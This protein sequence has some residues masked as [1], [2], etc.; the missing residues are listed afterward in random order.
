MVHILVTSISDDQFQLVTGGDDNSLCC[1][2]LTFNTGQPKVMTSACVKS[3][4][5]AQITGTGLIIDL[6]VA[7]SKIL[8]SKF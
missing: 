3:A 1:V 4:H 5:A 2:T 6:G 8:K 7:F